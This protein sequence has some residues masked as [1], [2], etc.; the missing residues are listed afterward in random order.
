MLGIIFGIGL[1][2]YFFNYMDNN[3]YLKNVGIYAVVN[4]MVSILKQIIDGNGISFLAT[5]ISSIIVSLIIIKI[6]EFTRANTKSLIGFILLT[7]LCVFA[8]SFVLT[9]LMLAVIF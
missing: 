1:D 7:E 8:I 4:F 5:L 9:A 3:S 6:M 2:W